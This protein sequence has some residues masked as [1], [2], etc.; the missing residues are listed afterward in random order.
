MSFKLLKSAKISLLLGSS[1]VGVIAILV[2]G[3]L[4]YRNNTSQ[5]NLTAAL[6]SARSEKDQTALSLADVQNE[7]DDLK[8]SDQVK[9]NDELEAK[10]L[11]VDRKNRSVSLSVKAK[12]AHEEAEAIKKYSKSTE[13]T[14]TNTLGDILKEKMANKEIE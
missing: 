3:F 4:I 2:F 6:A 9:R 12:D 11:N 10:I 14:M 1:I 5:N 13:S 8:N 7:L